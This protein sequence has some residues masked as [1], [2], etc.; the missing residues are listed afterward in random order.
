MF[1]GVSWHAAHAATVERLAPMPDPLPL[2]RRS[3]GRLPEAVAGAY[4]GMMGFLGKVTDAGLTTQGK[5]ASGRSADLRAG[6]TEAV[7]I[8]DRPMQARRH[9]RE[10]GSTI[11][12]S[13]G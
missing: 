8:S 5:G 13:D 4:L 2:H 6:A 3:D 7:G 9:R 11:S 12:F 10:P 1:T